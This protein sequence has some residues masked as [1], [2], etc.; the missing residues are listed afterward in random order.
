M[1]D[2][3]LEEKKTIKQLFK[4]YKRMDRGLIRKLE[5]LGFQVRR[6]PRHVKLYYK[7]FVFVCPSSCS[8][9]RGGRNF[10]AVICKTV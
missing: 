8:D 5:H 10:S 7:N 4:N 1:N 6:T 3:T 9:Y 2:F